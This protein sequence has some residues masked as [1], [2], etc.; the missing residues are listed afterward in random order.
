MKGRLSK[1]FSGLAMVLLMAGAFCF[2]PNFVNGSAEAESLSQTQK[3][4]NK[5]DAWNSTHGQQWNSS[6]EYSLSTG[7][8]NGKTMFYIES[9]DDLAYVAHEVSLG[10]A[11]Y[12]SGSFYVNITSK[13]IDLAGR[14]WTPIG[15]KTHPFAGKFY[16]NNVTIS[17]IWVTGESLAEEGSA[18][19]LFGNT[20]GALISDVNVAGFDA[21]NSTSNAGYL[22]GGAVSSIITN[23]HDLRSYSSDSSLKTI[24]GEDTTKVYLG[25]SIDGVNA[26][27]TTKDSVDNSITYNGVTP[28]GYVGVYNIEEGAF[29]SSNLQYTS[30]GNTTINIAVDEN[31]AILTG[32][33]AITHEM[34][35]NFFSESLPTLRAEGTVLYLF[36][37]GYKANIPALDW[38]N[39][40]V[41]NITWTQPTV[42]VIF[43]VGYGINQSK[44]YSGSYYD[45]TIEEV[46]TEVKTVV[47]P[48]FDFK[49]VYDESTFVHDASGKY[50]DDTAES[51]VV[52]VKWTALSVNSRVNIGFSDEKGNEMGRDTEKPLEVIKGLS[53]EK[54]GGDLE[55]KE[56]TETGVTAGYASYGIINH[57]ADANLV[58][59]VALKDGFAIPTTDG[60]VV[61]TSTALGADTLE[62]GVYI[63]F[64]DDMNNPPEYKVE[65]DEV[66]YIYTVTVKNVV[67]TSTKINI[68]IERKE[69]NVKLNFT[70]N[71]DKL[72]VTSSTHGDFRFDTTNLENNVLTIFAGDKFDVVAQ[73]KEVYF[74]LE[75]VALKFNDIE[76]ENEKMGVSLTSTPGKVLG[77]K[78]ELEKNIKATLNSGERDGGHFLPIVPSG[79]NEDINLDFVLTVSSVQLNVNVTF[80][81]VDR[82][83]YNGSKE[84][85]IGV[86]GS[87]GG[88]SYI[89]GEF[90]VSLTDG[91]IF[92]Y[93]SD[94]NYYQ[95]KTDSMRVITGANL[96]STHSDNGIH[97]FIFNGVGKETVEITYKIEAKKHTANISAII[98]NNANWLASNFI[99]CEIEN[100]SRDTLGE[101]G[102]YIGD[103]L[104][105][106]L[107][108][109]ARVYGNLVDLKNVMVGNSE[110]SM[111]YSGGT[112]TGNIVITES[113]IEEMKD[114]NETALQIKA[115]FEVYNVTLQFLANDAKLEE[116]PNNYRDINAING[117]QNAGSINVILQGSDNDLKFVL[118]NQGSSYTFRQ[119]FYGYSLVGWYLA[120]GDVLTLSGDTAFATIN[121][122]LS[123]SN[124]LNSIT[125]TT[126]INVMPIYKSKMITVSAKH[127]VDEN[128]EFKELYT[129]NGGINW[130]DISKQAVTQIPFT[131]DMSTHTIEKN[132]IALFRKAGYN[133]ASSWTI[134]GVSH[135]STNNST[136][137]DKVVLTFGNGFIT[138]WTLEETSK[139][140]VLSPNFINKLGFSVALKNDSIEGSLNSSF[141]VKNGTTIIF[142]S[143]TNEYSVTGENTFRNEHKNGYKPTGF[144]L[145][146]GKKTDAI[147]FGVDENG[148]VSITLNDATMLEYVTSDKYLVDGSEIFTLTTTYAPKTFSITVELSDVEINKNISS[149]SIDVVFGEKVGGVEGNIGLEY[150]IDKI[151]RKGFDLV[152]FKTFGATG[153]QYAT[154]NGGT[155]TYETFQPEGA[156][157]TTVYPVWARKTDYAFTQV[158]VDALNP[159][160]NGSSQ[161]VA[162]ATVSVDG[163][164]LSEFY[165]NLSLGNGE[166]IKSFS[167]SVGGIATDNVSV[168]SE[169][170]VNVKEYIFTLVIEDTLSNNRF[171]GND[172]FPL[173][174]KVNAGILANR[175]NVSGVDFK[176]YYTGNSS[177]SL[178]EGETQNYGTFSFENGE[179][180][181][182]I[183]QDDVSYEVF[184]DANSKFNVSEDKYAVNVYI[185]LSEQMA[186]NFGF[187]INDEGIYQVGTIVN[188]VKILPLQIKYV[189]AENQQG[190]AL[191][192]V[193]HNIKYTSVQ[194][195]NSIEVSQ[196]S[197]RTKTS[198]AGVYNSVD[199]IEIIGFSVKMNGV[200]VENINYQVSFDGEYIILPNDNVVNSTIGVRYITAQN[201][202]LTALQSMPEGNNW[203]YNISFVYNST[204]YSIV[205]DQYTFINQ[206]NNQII[207]TLVKVNDE[208]RIAMANGFSPIE[209]TV[210]LIEKSID[211]NLTLVDFGQDYLAKLDN[212]TEEASTTVTASVNGSESQNF[213]A[214]YTDAKK[215]NVF[216]NLTNTLIDSKT[217]PNSS[218][219]IKNGTSY[220]FNFDSVTSPSNFTFAEFKVEGGITASAHTI[221]A[222][223]GNAPAKAIMLWN[224]AEMAVTKE[225]EDQTYDFDFNAK[226]QISNSAMWSYTQYANCD[227]IIKLFKV[228]ETG[229]NEIAFAETGIW[230]L[231]R[232]KADEGKY[233]LY[234]KYTYSNPN[235]ERGAQF[236]EVSSKFEY[237]MNVYT[238]S[239]ISLA[240]GTNLTYNSKDQAGDL[241]IKVST[242][243][244][245]ITTDYISI[246]DI[247]ALNYFNISI[248]KGG[249]SVSQIVGAGE[250]NI[251]LSLI[252]G[253]NYGF[254]L[255]DNASQILLTVAK[256]AYTITDNDV[257]TGETDETGK[258]ISKI[259]FYFG[260]EIPSQIS[261]NVTTSV[262]E[263]LKVD[264]ER[265]DGNTDALEAGDYTVKLV[266]REYDNYTFSLANEGN[267]YLQVVRS[268]KTLLI[269]VADENLLTSVYNKNIISFEIVN[270]GGYKLVFTND[271]GE[272]VKVPL[273]LTVAEDGNYKT[274]ESTDS[275][276]AS[277]LNGV[278]FKLKNNKTDE[279]FVDAINAGIYYLDFEVSSTNY[280]KY[281]MR[282]D[283][284]FTIA[285][286]E[287]DVT[288]VTKT[289]DRTTSFAGAIIEVTGN[290]AGENVLIEG[291]Y[292]DANVG[293]GIEVNLTLADNDVNKN[294]VLKNSKANVGIINKSN[295]SI[296]L[297]FANLEGQFTFGDFKSGM[298]LEEIIAKIG[299]SQITIGSD[300][301]VIA[302]EDGIT[303]KFAGFGSTAFSTAGYAN[304]GDITLVFTLET[305]NYDLT[306]DAQR[307]FTLTLGK[308]A[309]SVSEDSVITKEYDGTTKLVDANIILDGVLLNGELI[310]TVSV[311]YDASSYA[312]NKVGEKQVNVVLTGAD[313]VNYTISA[314]PNGTIISAS[315]TITVDNDGN[316]NDWKNIIDND[317]GKIEGA[318]EKYTNFGYNP[319]ESAEELAKIFGLLVKPQRKGFNPVG[320]VF[321]GSDLTAQNIGEVLVSAYNNANKTAQISV[322]WGIANVSVSIAKPA[323][324]ELKVTVNGT[325]L[326]ANETDGRSVYTTEYFS[327]VKI[328]FNADEGMKLASCEIAKGFE[329]TVSSLTTIVGKKSDSVTLSQMKSNAELSFTQ[330]D[331]MVTVNFNEN[332][333]A[334]DSITIPADWATKTKQVAY[335]TLKAEVVKGYM[336][337]LTTTPGTYN[338]TGWTYGDSDT[339]VAD[340][341]TFADLIKTLFGGNNEFG[342][343]E[344][345]NDQTLSLKAVWTG[346][347]YTIKFVDTRESGAQTFDNIENVI[348]GEVIGQEFPS[349]EMSGL[350]QIWHTD[351]N[352]T[353]SG[354]NKE[355]TKDST[356][357][358]VGVLDNGKWTLTLYNVYTSLTFNLTVSPATNLKISVNGVEIKENT[359]TQITFNQTGTTVV[360]EANDGYD[361]EFTFSGNAE[362]ELTRE[363]NEFTIQ[364]IIANRTLSFRAN[365]KENELSLSLTNAKA[366]SDSALTNEITEFKAFTGN[367]N[368]V[369][370]IGADEGY[371]VS[372][373]LISYNG[374]GNVT[375]TLEGKG[376]KITWAGFTANGNISLSATP[377][378]N[379]LS[380]ANNS[381][382][383]Y[384]LV[385]NTKVKNGENVNVLTDAELKVVVVLKYGYNNISMT[386]SKAEIGSI[387][388]EDGQ[389]I[390]ESQDKTTYVFSKQFAVSG[391]KSDVVLNIDALAREYTFNVTAG[392]NG[393]VIS[394]GAEVESY[395]V[396]LTYGNSQ[397][398]VAKADDSYMLGSW[399]NDT[400]VLSNL[401]TFEFKA[402]ESNILTLEDLA[403]G[404]A[405]QAKFVLS[406]TTF[407]IDLPA[408]SKG[409]IVYDLG[410]GEKTATAGNLV[411]VNDVRFGIEVYIKVVV[412]EGYKVGNIEYSKNGAEV[413][414]TSEYFDEKT[415][416]ISYTLTENAPNNIKISIVADTAFVN[417]QSVLK[418]L[419][420]SNYGNDAGGKIYIAD[421]GYNKLSETDANISAPIVGEKVYGANYRYKTLTGT[422]LYFVAEVKPGFTFVASANSD[423]VLIE[424]TDRVENADKSQ[425]VKI[426]VTG[427]V[428]NIFVYG[429]FFADAQQI[430]VDFNNGT[431]GDVKGG[432]IYVEEKGALVSVTNNNTHHAIISAMTDANTTVVIKVRTNFNHSFLRGEDGKAI[433]SGLDTIMAD[434]VDVSSITDFDF[435]AG[436]LEEFTIT[437]VKPV[438]AFN[439]SVGVEQKAYKLQFKSG[440]D[441]IGSTS[442]I[443]GEKFTLP[444][445]VI[446]QITNSKN[447][448]NNLTFEGYF[449]YELG[450]GNK[451]V[452]NKA[453]V[454]DLWYENGFVWNGSVYEKNPNFEVTK[455]D[456][457]D[458][459]FTLYASW[460]GDKDK[461][462]I[463]FIPEKLKDKNLDIKVT[464]IIVGLSQDTSWTSVSKRFYAEVIT[465]TKIELE[466][467][468]FEGYTFHSWKIRR[469][470]NGNVTEESIFTE[471]YTY[472]AG[473][474][475]VTIVA[476]YFVNFS[477][478]VENNG[479]KASLVQDGKE[480]SVED[481]FDSTK[482]FKLVAEE[483]AGYTFVGWYLSDGTTWVGKG[484]TSNLGEKTYWTLE[485]NTIDEPFSYIAVFEGKEINVKLDM[486]QATV[487][488]K[489]R[490]SV[491]KIFLNGTQVEDINSFT[492]RVGDEIT[493]HASSTY[494]YGIVWGE[495]A[496]FSPEGT[497]VN[498]YS[499]YKYTILAED[500][501]IES[502]STKSTL[503]IRPMADPTSFRVV[504]GITVENNT[505]TTEKAGTLTY[506]GKDL[507]NGSVIEGILFGNVI[508]IRVNLSRNYDINRVAIVSRGVTELDFETMGS[509]Y[510][511]LGNEIIIRTNLLENENLRPTPDSAVQVRIN[512]ARILW[513][514]TR[515]ESLEGEGTSESPYLI[516]S[517]EDLAF[518]AYMVNK[519]ES[520]EYAN[521]YYRL[522]K[523]LNLIDKFWEPIGTQT[524]AFNGTFDM[525]TYKIENVEHFT[526]YSDPTTSYNGVFRYLGSNARVLTADN[527]LA[528]ALGI[529][530]GVIILILLILLI[531]LLTRRAKKKKMDELANS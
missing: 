412:D 388:D 53:L 110:A 52:Y 503:F 427:I 82:Y 444:V 84:N 312:D 260:E 450:Q 477:L 223:T 423:K 41:S 293:N 46:K 454:I 95:Y 481:G 355:Y 191:D 524:N 24:N 235:D 407:K 409:Y 143:N 222:T 359:T 273:T 302:D 194:A 434:S 265:N 187:D 306:D 357:N 340:T 78:T 403:N 310:D 297:T 138:S 156:K 31:G 399:M 36:R 529:A 288:S 134:S 233:K 8:I 225:A 106:T 170:D 125:G 492:A 267:T 396:T 172:T 254:T 64:E 344:I 497:V 199:N 515:S 217:L 281:S 144:S 387:F 501:E 321:N 476:E 304:A 94:N 96:E 379:K 518:L 150:F 183:N 502:G 33:N 10:N 11:E 234:V 474:G 80:G 272:Q 448:K 525:G 247:L 249:T 121:S 67:S 262:K 384:I 117:L 523:D 460:L 298:T 246:S 6:T 457:Y 227:V 453:N 472:T 337:T 62:A 219:Y 322:K 336:P 447:I 416:T 290:V 128:D 509:G 42:T 9:S 100:K 414:D 255:A 490:V 87:V 236:K 406:A 115:T 338:H 329:G 440:E 505:Y 415:N 296:N 135:V 159:Y 442:V 239:G 286:R 343:F 157:N 20:N 68:I 232:T 72:N 332:N 127:A 51:L 45:Y 39:G 459:V 245:D 517:E 331:I 498:G 192:G 19:G 445:E 410:D 504:F 333:P 456:E 353:N 231:G 263:T 147:N 330:T 452:D 314:M 479:G 484:D 446:D 373:N 175:L 266:D 162:K 174:A 137:G 522:T 431:S 424:E 348:F 516:S 439:L 250:Y 377:K 319:D 126:S 171:G 99:G 206:E 300:N 188:A 436:Y 176:S 458:G 251:T 363:G 390:G 165:K 486:S 40:F 226:T 309:I 495:K 133:V 21:F 369:F 303:L 83:D 506:A 280:V 12:V 69:I 473:N 494:G 511:K 468:N 189:L 241:R 35:N 426:K 155:W 271:K 419:Q 398:L 105:I 149:F 526:V 421:S 496:K 465:G 202:N 22:V 361:F 493:L 455:N 378:Q 512:F 153:I 478:T 341:N 400:R 216:F 140:I 488:D 469:E 3:F 350:R 352:G 177:L 370:Y 238:V 451:Y 411:T 37:K 404:G 351:R 287:V 59:K 152:G 173:T 215:V 278:D 528:I 130:G 316:L 425:T 521:A 161:N 374:T 480:V 430:V 437:I 73:V 120:N 186:K 467:Y 196:T 119:A 28:A 392:N 413:G 376:L 47:R 470:E 499:V 308:L 204:G 101:N 358:N 30:I 441:I 26:T 362:T 139:E 275:E 88:P 264:F 475:V 211:A 368:A 111:T 158:S 97:T 471:N 342:A 435:T 54:E 347:T 382:V 203:D 277:A 483:N 339:A 118:E 294:Y 284:Y 49:G 212:F 364:N 15:T 325:E 17:N 145:S 43:N 27:Y 507:T 270:E 346:E 102:F 285:Q 485:M 92:V 2:V 324:F 104:G 48:G 313:S 365:P 508:T 386:S 58:F 184:G 418:M 166:T 356:L 154:N 122:Y 317:N 93:I 89:K 18:Y 487:G 349:A 380:F 38:S 461:I 23:C 181:P 257:Y 209:F 381:M 116:A 132:I 252:D 283:T 55:S 326:T 179:T 220:E 108:R 527:T 208:I 292:S 193:L 274:L 429:Q 393:K 510:N 432:Q 70:G 327:D 482:P 311:D 218:F 462:T 200:E 61:A 443:Y 366:Y 291:S 367:A 395:Q 242:T 318:V 530:G 90:E 500:L 315:I 185:S 50:V 77:D 513:I 56:S 230:N 240:E 360:V 320:F 489:E 372:S 282:E 86:S 228:D 335:N 142:D 397:T 98:N 514:D 114:N 463:D 129:S 123:N 383:D 198:N 289:F 243:R 258:Q 44:V 195:P 205:E 519:A 520:K 394:A 4:E 299:A 276:Y 253:E 136:T 214:V 60:F 65:Y 466:A 107:T 422:T 244:P 334:S 7:I 375:A 163:S 428:P 371:E 354:N 201:G 323:N 213:Y 401:A 85:F 295:E 438:N 237:S 5:E 345:A 190:F 178:V 268:P 305:G 25:G 464:D 81:G 261:I 207:F 13:S 32:N 256:L 391:I 168:L 131:H 259:R 491:S 279:S 74:F 197:L 408:N 182:N 16:G 224:M 66:N 71:I 148:S 221:T 248:T 167:M 164:A 301:K 34:S 14:L 151:E 385:N 29:A 75:N 420:S 449:T 180:V 307:T 146:G 103:T 109:N 210:T 91:K 405:I 389:E 112:W 160:Y 229:E 113:F 169:T 417:V 141:T 79:K 328:A 531:V 269:K 402:D 57:S 1:C 63:E 124:F 433:V 76:L